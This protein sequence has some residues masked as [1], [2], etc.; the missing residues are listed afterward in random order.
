MHEP[1]VL[2]FVNSLEMVG[3]KFVFSILCLENFQFYDII[4]QFD[5]FDNWGKQGQI[6]HF[7]ISVLNYDIKT[8]LGHMGCIGN[9]IG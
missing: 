4:G 6:G 8:L 2:S 5:N 3:M 9:E 1:Y 7:G